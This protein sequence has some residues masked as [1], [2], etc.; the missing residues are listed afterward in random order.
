MMTTTMPPADALLADALTLVQALH[1]ELMPDS[2]MRTLWAQAATL[3][4]ATGLRYRNAAL[5]IDIDLGE[6]PH[7]ASYHLDYQGGDLGELA[8]RF[9]QRVDDEV[10]A[11]AEGHIAL[12]LTALRNALTHHALVQRMG[13]AADN[14]H[15]LPAATPR[16]TPGTSLDDALV[17]VS[18]DGYA[19]VREQHGE[20][21]AQTLI[22][23][24]HQQ[25]REGLRDADCVF[26]IDE[27]LLAV[28]LPRTSE[29]AALDVAAKIR[30]L[31]AGLHLRD[32]R[33]STQLTACMG[34]AGARAA[35]RPEDVLERAQ[36]ALA[37]AQHEGAN[38]VRTAGNH[39]RAGNVG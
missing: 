2:L 21:W 20:A 4:G 19:E 27:G 8:L 34:V 24:T 38:S 26:Q 33:L 16:R 35:N 10:L 31:I 37:L 32:G 7:T 14:V 29:A 1:A 28:L 3:I 36:Q 5:G 18:L 11:T 25:L 22:Q 23:T 39:S 12:A 9:R 17:L 13:T 6:G 30:V 15:V